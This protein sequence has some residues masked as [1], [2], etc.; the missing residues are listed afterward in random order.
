MMKLNFMDKLLDGVEIKWKTL[1][2]VAELYGGLSGKNKEDFDNGNALYISYK[3]IFDNIEINFDK[4]ESVKVT[5]S[6][7]QHEVK[8]GDIL[9]TGSSE[10]AEEVGMSSSVTTK[11]ENKVY[12]NSFSFGVRFN[13]DIHIIPQFSKYLFRSHLMRTEIAKTA[14]GVTR[15]NISK[16][17][18][19]KLLIPIPPLKVQEEIVRILDAFTELTAELI[20]ELTAR[21]KQYTYY[22]DK[23][24]TFE[25]GEIEWKNLY[26]V[27]EIFDS[28]HQTPQ[29]TEGGMSMIRVTDIKG[30]LLNLDDTL[31][32][33]N[34]VFE[35]FTKKYLPQKY[36]LVM[37]R[38]GSYGNVSIV[39]S[40]KA[41]CM[42]Q[43]TVVIHPL[44]NSKFLYYILLSNS[45]QSFIERNVGGG[46]QKTLSLKSIK[47]IP[48]PLV[49]E[50]EQARI[51]SIL[52]KFDALT[53]SITEGLPREIEL[54]QKQYEY[55]RNMLLSFPKEEVEE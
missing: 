18:F 27:A 36:D 17:R 31:K 45:V 28:L 41:V 52:N 10:T 16:A 26:E 14:S 21:K 35:I 47:E 23:L 15:F 53:S 13:D 8:Y 44:I 49:N 7:N 39:P 20:A 24:L 40:D 2:D 46:S 9:F 38:V 34:E 37:S 48:I 5:D 22:R 3:N 30:G 50:R 43:N 19:K 12:L 11:F 51:V 55:Y 6:E 4:L 32:V 42:G 54:R 1:G 25:E 33:S 29:Y